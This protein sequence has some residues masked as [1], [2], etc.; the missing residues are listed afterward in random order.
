MKKVLKFFSLNLIFVYNNED[1]K[2]VMKRKFGLHKLL[3]VLLRVLL[4]ALT[5]E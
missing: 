2:I 3:R 4:R 5:I 1:K